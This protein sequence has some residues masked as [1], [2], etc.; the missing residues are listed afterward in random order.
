MALSVALMLHELGTNSTKYGALSGASGTV[1]VNWR[2][3][4]V[5]HLQWTER[6]GPGVATPSKRGFGTTLIQQS[7]K[8][9]G[10]SAQMLCE[11]EG[12]SWQIALPLPR[13]G[14]IPDQHFVHF[15]GSEEGREL[16]GS[17]ALA[18]RR[19]LVVEDEPI[20]GLDV[21]AAL[22]NAKAAVEGPIGTIEKALEIIERSPLDGA[23]LDANLNG[24]R[25]D[26]IALS[27]TR[28]G[29][30]FAFVTGYDREALPEAFRG[31]ALLKK[32][33]NHEQLTDIAAALCRPTSQVLRLRG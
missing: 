27:L 31:A 14:V 6:G 22:E 11:A 4:D 15:T 24:R 25:T 5:L 3:D 16:S 19:F 26:E 21:V 2:T 17:P 8:A 28:R 18:G 32:P 7:A 29:V 20:L 23:L 33:F 1:T 10:G 13:D 9:Q 30:P 12:I